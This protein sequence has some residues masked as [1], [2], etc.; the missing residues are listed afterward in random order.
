M[1]LP[2]VIKD[3]CKK[4]NSHT[5]HKLK[6]FKSGNARTLSRGQRRNIA[7]KAGYGGKYQFT[8][9]VKKQNKK[10]V[11]TAECTVCSTK[12]PFVISKR[13]KKIELAA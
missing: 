11:F 9:I 12:H 7:K 10:P 13:M 3:Y 5:D 1:D 8:A 2:K 6:Q 4:C